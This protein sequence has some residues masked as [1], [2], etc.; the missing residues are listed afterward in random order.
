MEDQCRGLIHLGS[1]TTIINTTTNEVKNFSYNTCGIPRDPNDWRNK[2][3]GD[4]FTGR[5]FTG[6]EHLPEFDLI[7]MNGRI[8]DPMVGRFLSPDPFVQFPEFPDSCNRYSYALNNPL[9]YIDP[10]GHSNS[11]TYDDLY[12]ARF[13]RDG[14]TWNP[15]YGWRFPQVQYPLFILILIVLT[16]S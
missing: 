3:E 8:Y 15:F 4:L 6:H 10:S 7:N 14:T 9:R 12:N 2:L 13:M 11:L 5:G 16:L 1:L